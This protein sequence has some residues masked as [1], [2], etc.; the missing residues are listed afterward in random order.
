[1]AVPPGFSLDDIETYPEG[2]SHPRGGGEVCR[3]GEWIEPEAPSAPLLDETDL[4]LVAAAVAV[5][6]GLF[7]LAA[8]IAIMVTVTTNPRVWLPPAAIWWATWSFGGI[9]LG[10]M[11]VSGGRH[12][13]GD[14]RGWPSPSG[15]IWP[16]MRPPSRQ[17]PRVPFRQ[18]TTATRTSPCQTWQNRRPPC[19]RRVALLRGSESWTR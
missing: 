19:R 4:G 16:A 9:A 10:F 15:G 14:R 8:W 1:M 13:R 12:R 6:L 5:P 11:G 2:A 7:L 17:R 18:P 3:N